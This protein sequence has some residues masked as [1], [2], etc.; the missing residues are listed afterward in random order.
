MFI[1]F[2]FLLRQHGIKCSIKEYLHLMEALDKGVIGPDL[3]AFYYLSRSILVKHEGQLDAF[4]VLFGKYFKGKEGMKNEDFWKEVPEE[5]LR[6]ELEKM[7]NPEDLEAIEAMGGLD[8]LIERFK[9]LMEQQDEQHEGGNTY[10]GAQ[11]TSPY[12]NDGN[13]PEGFKIGQ[14]KGSGNRNG[15]KVWDKRR[16]ANLNDQMELNT[17]NLKMVLKRLRIL[18]REG[19]PDELDLNKTIRKTSENAGMLDIKMR[20]TRRNRVK[21]LILFD[22]GGSMDDHVELCSRLFSAAKYE[23]KHMEY[24]YFHNCLY[25]FV[26]KDNSRRYSERISTWELLNK[27]NRD[28][29]VIFVGD[30]AMSPVEIM[31]AGGSVEHWNQEP[32]MVWLQ[33]MKEHFSHLVWINP[34]P[35][36]AWNYYK[37]T[38][39]LRKFTDYRMFPMTLDGITQAMKGLKDLRIRFGEEG[40]AE[41]YR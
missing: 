31:Y 4:D 12:G 11:G 35:P 22:I 21:V 33:R 1:D 23:F 39:I 38:E 26:W 27:Y 25:D 36:Y 20:P 30:A 15:I 5:W 7:I 37:S 40:D 19:I 6:A 2:F 10:I 8:A 41:A 3:E 13:N 32:G 16:Y 29:K 28:Y 34:N 24:Y 17:R 14:G 18:T 9:E